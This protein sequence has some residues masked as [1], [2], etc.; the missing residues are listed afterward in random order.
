MQRRR[1]LRAALAAVFLLTASGAR[2]DEPEETKE[3]RLPL[4][5]IERPLTLPRLVLNP[6]AELNVTRD[7]GDYAVNLA[8]AAAVGITDDW[9]IH[10]VVAPLQLSPGVTYGQADQPG[11]SLG[12]TYRMLSRGTEAALRLDVTALTLPHTTGAIVRPG[13]PFRAHAGESVRFDW[14]VFVNVTASHTTTVGVQLPFA[15]AVDI[16]E[17]LHVGVNT[18]LTLDSIDAPGSLAIP[19]GFFAGY[20]IG[21]KDGPIL[22][23]DPFFRWPKVASSD[24]GPPPWQLGLEVGGFFYL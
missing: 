23:I 16:V 17:P 24:P 7:S 2:A 8:L 4:S 20:A 11:P 22:D 6:V 9:E 15:L 5:Y 1:L 3:G 21:G 18:G 19:L 13:M 12:T 14:G 10:A